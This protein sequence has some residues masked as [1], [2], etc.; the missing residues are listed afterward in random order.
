M[1]LY[2]TLGP[3]AGG[4]GWVQGSD[5]RMSVYFPKLQGT[6][7]GRDKTEINAS[8]RKQDFERRQPANLDFLKELGG[9]SIYEK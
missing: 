3:S 5:G 4:W 7:R 6:R 8:V 2:D 9:K 1:C